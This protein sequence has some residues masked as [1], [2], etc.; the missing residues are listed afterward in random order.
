MHAVDRNDEVLDFPADDDNSEVALEAITEDDLL[1]VVCD[2]QDYSVTL[3]DR[4][5][6]L[7]KRH[8][9]KKQ[10]LAQASHLVM[11]EE[12]QHWL[13]G[14]DSSFLLVDGHCSEING[15]VSAMSIF[16]AALSES[17]S[18]LPRKTH[19][20]LSFFCGQHASDDDT[21]PGPVGMI[22]SLICQLVLLWPGDSLPSLEFLNEDEGRLW[23]RVQHMETSALCDVF[24]EL[25]WR[26]PARATVYCIVDGISQFET[27]L[28]GRKEDL[29]DIVLCIQKCI[30]D[31]WGL[32][33]GDSGSQCRASLKVVL[34][35]ADKSI[36]IG[37][38]IPEE[39]QVD[40]RSGNLNTNSVVSEGQFMVDIY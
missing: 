32:D 25:V 27:S 11:T 35:S 33:R 18:G 16:C 20:L 9:F 24:E 6:V 12:F 2:Q 4:Y 31:T 15:K 30:S 8:L 5:A 21:F 1:Q 19:A 14:P 38:L 23:D 29:Q 22:R 10:S 13:K 34:V 37:R 26:L 28:G 7:Q 36:H 3:D 40:L 17:L 39:F